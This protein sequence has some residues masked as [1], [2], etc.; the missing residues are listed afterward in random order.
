MPAFYPTRNFTVRY[1]LP[2]A[3]WFVKR[4]S[5]DNQGVF[6]RNEDNT[7][8]WK[9]TPDPGDMVYEIGRGPYYLTL[10]EARE[11]IDV[12]EFP[13]VVYTD[14]YNDEYQDYYICNL[15]TNTPDVPASEAEAIA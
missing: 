9:R 3:A 11:V 6:V 8:S 13:N 7:F 2:H 5:Q 12:A 1:G 15:A 10:D 4:S 14:D